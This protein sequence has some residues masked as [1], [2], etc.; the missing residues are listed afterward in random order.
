MPNV[1][2]GRNLVADSAKLPL[3]RRLVAPWSR[4]RWDHRAR[5]HIAGDARSPARAQDG[6]VGYES[7]T[8]RDPLGRVRI[9]LGLDQ[10]PRYGAVFHPSSLAVGTIPSHDLQIA[11]DGKTL[12]TRGSR[13]VTCCTVSALVVTLTIIFVL[14]AI[15]V[16]VGFDQ[17]NITGGL[18][19]TPLLWIRAAGGLFTRDTSLNGIQTKII[20]DTEKLSQNFAT[21]SQTRSSAKV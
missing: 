19:T 15:D 1:G 8:C 20:A 12:R 3:P 16:L 18:L 14:S 4:T 13:G 5:A 11:A 7:G 6:A 21:W 17:T 10:K 2:V 9:P